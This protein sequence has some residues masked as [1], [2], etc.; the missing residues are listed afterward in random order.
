MA[1]TSARSNGLMK[2]LAY[3]EKNL[4]ALNIYEMEKFNTHI[5]FIASIFILSLFF[6]N[7]ILHEGAILDN[8]HY[9]NDLT[10]LS[11]NTKESLKNNE[12]PLWTPYFYAGHSMLAIPESYMFDLNF[13]F[14][15]LFRNIYL[16]MNLALI[17]YFFLAG[18]GIYILVYNLAANKKAAFISAIIYMFNGFMHSFIIHGHINVLEG[19]ALLPFV[20]L[21]VYKAL[22][23]KMW[24]FYSILAGI[25]FALQILSGS[26]IFFFYTALLVFFYMAFSLIGKSFASRLIKAGFIGIVIVVVALGVA[27]IKLLPVLEFTKLS[28]RAVN[29]SF[30]E[31]LGHPVNLKEIARILVT[32]IG[33]ADTSAAVGIIG[34][35][36][37]ICSFLNYK[38]KIIAFSLILVVFSLLFA[39]GTFVADIMYKIP[40]FDKQRHI[41]R[42]L[43][44]FAFAAS[45]LIAYGF[46]ILSEKLRKYTAYLKYENL[47]FAGIVFLILLELLFLQD[48]PKGIKVTEPDEIKLLDYI[49]K[50]NSMLRTINLAQKDIIGSA[51]YNYYA[52]KGISEVKGGGGIWVNDYVAF[53][54][55]AQQSLNSKMLSVLNVKYIVSDKMLEADNLSLV[56]KFN[57]CRECPVGNA[58]GPYLFKNERFLP[59]YHVVPNA[60]L[61]VG[62]NLQVKQLIYNLMFLNWEPKNAVMIEGTNINDYS[63][64]FLEKFKIIFLL[65]DSVDQNGIGKLREYVNKGGTIVPDI[66]NGKNSISDE[67][68]TAMFSKIAGSYKEINISEYSNNKVALNLDGETG[69]LVLAERFAYFPGWSAKINGRDVKVLNS[70]N[71]ISSLYLDGEKGTLTFEY[72]PDS[73]RRG[74]LASSLA[75]VAIAIYLGRLI[76]KKKIK[77]GD[78]LED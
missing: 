59:R 67:E 32:D 49:S 1:R 29:V 43:M 34:M 10:F 20:F 70:D 31:F 73:Y 46:I 21:F 7:S 75:V 22:K 26:M 42:A 60:I 36:L 65:R 69:W 19:Y 48:I 56:G 45:I 33:Y 76:Y 16:A 27:A 2:P 64:D 13:L 39:S 51:G 15:Y 78:Q 12:L 25:C 77:S 40:G 53:V 61:V 17:L 8:I 55:I 24:I 66:L 14:I 62:S 38:K 72:K 37:L 18:I 6:L 71:V 35:I 9:I 4:K 30:E 58:F 5:V 11:Y 47:F 68:I 3:G 23:S 44:L 63:V 50:D 57:E 74:K 54:G 52:Q 41:E 28:N